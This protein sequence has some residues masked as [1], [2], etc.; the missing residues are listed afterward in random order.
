M[1][2]YLMRN[3]ELPKSYDYTYA[4]LRH[5]LKMEPIQAEQCC[6]IT[7]NNGQCHIKQG[8]ILLI[9]GYAK[10]LS[11]KGFTLRVTSSVL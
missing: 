3:D 2:L 4:S 5:I 7:Q 10:Q 9:Q 11:E 6:L 1:H 8:P